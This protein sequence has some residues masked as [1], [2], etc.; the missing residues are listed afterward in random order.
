MGTKLKDIIESE[1][2]SVQELKGRILVVDAFNILYQFLSTIRMRDGSL[3]RDSKGNVTSH[4]VGLFSRTTSL[5]EQG[6]RL[7]FV[8]DG[9]APELKAQERAKRKEAKEEAKRHYEAALAR[10]DIEEMRKYA[11]RTTKLTPEMVEE[12][13][14]LLE[15]LGLPVIQAPSEGEAQAASLVRDK[16]AWAEVSQDYD[17]LLF[18]V[19]RM[20]KNLTLT[21][22][23]KQKSKLS[24]ETIKPEVISLS[25][26]LRKL[27]ITHD[28]LIALGML[29]G[30]DFNNGGIPGIGP[31]RGL[32]MLREHGDDFSSLF[33]GAAWDEH[34]NIAWEAVF[35]LFK[36]MPVE[37]DIDLSWGDV[38]EDA[39]RE[40]LIEEHDF[41]E[42][43]I[44][45]A[46][47]RLEK[48][49]KENTQKGLEEFV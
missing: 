44:Q 47:R 9:E 32:K 18:G 22:R 26:N 31:K 27:D 11:S 48:A 35:E 16:K 20:V 39:L 28:Q 1:E 14:K 40:L 15:A 43:R 34:F 36:N 4:L 8:F 41:A 29:V 17:C 23:K 12:A 30:T 2:V 49:A 10:E 46:V 24:Y 45:D 25:D 7:A 6:L 37:E 42:T 19:P 3:L 33:Q 13:K 5:M 21:Q 38:D